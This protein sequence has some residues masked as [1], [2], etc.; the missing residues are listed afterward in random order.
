MVFVPAGEFLM[1]SKELGDDEQ[2]VHPV[3]LD[4]FWLDRYEV[5]NQQFARFV[6]DIGYQTE[7]E[8]QGWGWVWTGTEWEE[9]DGANWQHPQGSASTIENK[10]D[11]PVVLVSWNDAQAYCNWAGKRLP[12]EAEWEKA[13]RGPLLESGYAWGTEFNPANANTTAAELDDTTPVGR[14]SPQG[15]SYYGAADLTGNAAEWVADW[16]SSDYYSHSPLENPAGPNDGTYK[17]LRGGSWLLDEVYGRT[18]FRYNIRPDY[19]YDFT[20]FRCSSD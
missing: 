20:G 18:A 5:T 19:T 9:T 7:A 14:F 16:Y 17:I 3:Y 11:H 13:A 12:T 10:I 15:D 6:A 1:G 2:P 4:D 8:K